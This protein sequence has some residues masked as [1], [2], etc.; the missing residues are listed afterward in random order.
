[1]VPATLPPVMSRRR[2]PTVTIGGKDAVVAFSGL[3]GPGL[4]Q[5]S[6]AV[7]GSLAAGT[8]PVVVTQ[9]GI[10]SPSTAVMKIATN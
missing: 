8:Y 1:M 2:P 5:I 9:N 7:P 4:Y 6:V 10:S 3:T